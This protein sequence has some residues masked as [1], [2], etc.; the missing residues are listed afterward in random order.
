[1]GLH[2]PS[3]NFSAAEGGYRAGLGEMVGGALLAND[4]DP[5]KMRSY[6]GNWGKAGAITRDT[7]LT[8]ADLPGAASLAWASFPCQDVSLAGDRQ[9]LGGRALARSGRSGTL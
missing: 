3:T 2:W 8:T 7:G 1:M 6:V 5:A 9:G 4:N